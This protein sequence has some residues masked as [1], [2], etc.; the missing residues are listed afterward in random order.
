MKRQ[1][2]K[3][4]SIP[5]FNQHGKQHLIW[6]RGLFN[7]IARTHQTYTAPKFAVTDD[8]DRRTRQ[9]KFT[10]ACVPLL[11]STPKIWQ[12]PDGTTTTGPSFQWLAGSAL[13]NNRMGDTLQGPAPYSTKSWRTKMFQTMEKWKRQK[14]QHTLNRQGHGTP[15]LDRVITSHAVILNDI[16]TKIRNSLI[17]MHQMWASSVTTVLSA[18]LE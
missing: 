7:T 8:F 16:P 2:P 6:G 11:S 3:I 18:T 9:S 14:C 17:S 4:N 10:P 15:I 13:S 5:K 12:L 1:R